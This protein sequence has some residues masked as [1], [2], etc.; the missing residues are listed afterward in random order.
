MSIYDVSTV[1]QIFTLNDTMSYGIKRNENIS[2]K[3]CIIAIRNKK[4]IIFVG[5]L[6][7]RISYTCHFPNVS[8]DDGQFYW[9][10]FIRQPLSLYYS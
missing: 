7:E 6:S 9:I 1:L 10:F 3:R 2:T 8:I 5:R 4:A